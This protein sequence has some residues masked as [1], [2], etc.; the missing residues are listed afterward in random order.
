MTSGNDPYPLITVSTLDNLGDV[1]A[2]LTFNGGAVTLVN[3]I[4]ASASAAPGA[5]LAG[6]VGYRSSEYDSQNRDYEDQTYSVDPA[7]GTI[8]TAAL[9][10]YT[11]STTCQRCPATCAS[12][13]SGRSRFLP[14][15]ES[16]RKGICVIGKSACH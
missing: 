10:S 7:T 14:K 8:S 11:F 3:A 2:A 4:A 16:Q 12:I 5:V 9:S 1:T 15:I 13:G 6:L